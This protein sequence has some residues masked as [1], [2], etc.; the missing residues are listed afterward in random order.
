[1]TGWNRTFLT[2]PRPELGQNYGEESYWFTTCLTAT[3][4][5]DLNRT[6]CLL[7]KP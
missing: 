4:A 7:T 1:M 5:I 2:L 3:N 6:G